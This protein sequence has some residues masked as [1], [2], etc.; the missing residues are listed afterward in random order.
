LVPGV[1]TIDLRRLPSVD[2]VLRTDAAAA[3]ASH[4]GRSLVVTAI[5]GAL[6][7]AREGRMAMITAKDIAAAALARLEADAVPRL[8][9]VFN[10]TGTVLHTNL[11]RALL[12]E[13]A[14]QAA[15][16]AM[17]RAV[18]IEFDLESGRR[19]ERDDHLRGLL[20]ELTGA[21]DATIV[22]NN[23][24][25]ILLVL[26]TLAKGVKRS[27]RVA[28]SSRSVAPFACRRS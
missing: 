12:A 23:A 25:A 22:N 8:R 9:P 11:G 24:A 13:E 7:D 19:G 6:S 2:E 21:E 15:L 4:H 3:A 1:T 28:S 17:R 18:A 27:S 20:I 5:R 16:T 26:N 10:L 14:A